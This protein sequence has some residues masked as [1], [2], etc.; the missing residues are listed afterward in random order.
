MTNEVTNEEL[1]KQV[2]ELTTIIE[3]QKERENRLL[4]LVSSPTSWFTEAMKLRTETNM[5]MGEIAVA[6]G[7][8]ENTVSM[9]FKRMKKKAA[10][11]LSCRPITT[12]ALNT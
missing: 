10:Q 5:T 6:V 2:L 11:H 3:A 8:K 12:P 4:N 1:R 9:R 7:Q